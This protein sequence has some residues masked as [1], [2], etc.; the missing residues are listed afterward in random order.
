MGILGELFFFKSHVLNCCE[1]YGKT[2]KLQSPAFLQPDIIALD[3]ARMRSDS[4]VPTER[5]Q[6][7]IYFDMLCSKTRGEKKGRRQHKMEQTMVISFPGLRSACT[8]VDIE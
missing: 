5:F 2:K 1:V 7:L 3:C 4:S 6:K 8:L